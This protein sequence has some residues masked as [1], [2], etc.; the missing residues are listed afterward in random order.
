MDVALAVPAA[1]GG[2]HPSVHEV[3][4]IGSRANG[5]AHELSDW[6]FSVEAHDFAA[7]AR[8]LPRLVAPL[9][10]VAQQWDRFASHAC[11]ML[12]LPGPAKID[13]LFLDQKR[14]WS[15]AWSVSPDTLDEID[16][17]F[18]DWILWLEQKRRGGR[19]DVLQA[20]LHDLQELLL[21]PI[22]AREEARS[23]AE[24]TRAYLDARSRLERGFGFEVPRELERVVL[25]VLDA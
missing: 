4:R 13:L 23:V 16:V 7:V 18:W 1:L 21:R 5:G 11:Y 22:G 2:R 25:P 24:A 20:S 10:A 19:D 6:D 14:E 3:R 15:P 9:G 12:V 8:D 17:H